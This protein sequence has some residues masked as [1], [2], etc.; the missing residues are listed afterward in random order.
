MFDS[1]GTL[2]TIK[3]AKEVLEIQGFRRL[4]SKTNRWLFSSD[5]DAPIKNAIKRYSNDYKIFVDIGAGVGEITFDV[6]S[7]FSKCICFEP[8]QI[9]Y[10]TLISNLKKTNFNNII[11]YNCA[12]G[13]IKGTRDFYLSKQSRWNNRFNVAIKE[14]GEEFDLSQVEVNTLDHIFDSLG[15]NEPCVIKIDVEGSEPQVMKGAQ[16][17]LENDCVI[18]SEFSSWAMNV[19]NCNPIDYIKLMK[20]MGYAF[21]NLDD[22]PI[23]EKYLIRLS[24]LTKN[25]KRVTEDF[26]IKK[27]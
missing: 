6:A 25:K 16:R 13:E 4:L 2:D 27:I 5:Y 7:Y 17:I 18:I 14:E 1:Y 26:I 23:D 20:S 24:K 9:N 3:R 10:Q 8:S 15:I 12:L 19:N 22:S 21:Y 11:T